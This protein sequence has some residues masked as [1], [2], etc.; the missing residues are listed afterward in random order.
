MREVLDALCRH[1]GTGSKV[2]EVPMGPAELGVC[3]ALWLA[4]YFI[5]SYSRVNLF[6]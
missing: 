1:A 5:I 4:A 2:R 3:L 6:R